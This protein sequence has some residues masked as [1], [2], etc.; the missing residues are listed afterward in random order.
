M[1][2][3][4]SRW[5]LRLWG[6]KIVGTYP[7]HIKKYLVIVIPHTSWVDFPLGVF[8]RAAMKAHHIKFLGK[9]S[10]F[11]PPFGWMF[12]ALGGYPVDRSK[13]TNFVQAVVDLYNEKEAFVIALA[14]E[15]TR[16]K[17]DK[18]RTG[19]YYIALGAN[20]PILMVKM[21]Y[22]HKEVVWHEDLLYPSGDLEKDLEIVND[23]YRGTRGKVPEKSYLYDN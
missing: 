21:D 7:R 4:I 12:K 22:G 18:L 11:K 13:R 9:K 17:V 16:Q 6:F 8:V 10:L 19:F 2:S 3:L 1:F 5:I 23:F 14:P 20:V 15:G